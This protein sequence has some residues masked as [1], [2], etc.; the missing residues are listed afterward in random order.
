MSI[1]PN[2]IPN[3]ASLKDYTLRMVKKNPEMRVTWVTAVELLGILVQLEEGDKAQ[4]RLAAIENEEKND[5]TPVDELDVAD[6]HDMLEQDTE[7]YTAAMMKDSGLGL[8]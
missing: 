3:D 6:V 5:Q 2:E 1:K 4:A 7:G 8:H